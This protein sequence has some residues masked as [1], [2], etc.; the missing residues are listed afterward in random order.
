MRIRTA[1]KMLVLSGF[2]FAGVLTSAGC[3]STSLA[4]GD[5]LSHKE[6]VKSGASSSQEIAWKR[7]PLGPSAA[8]AQ[9]SNSASDPLKTAAFQGQGAAKEQA[10][11]P[12]LMPK[13]TPEPAPQKT[14]QGQPV[15]LLHGLHGKHHGP[16]PPIALP[17][18]VN[19]GTVAA[20][21][22]AVP[23]PEYIIRPPDVLLIESLREKEPL[24]F[25]QPIFGPHAVG[26]D[27]KINLGLY[28]QI[29]VAGLTVDQ[30]RD[31]V[32]E[33]VYRR[34]TPDEKRR[35]QIV[36]NLKLSVT[37][38]NSSV[39]YV[40]TDGAGL[41]EQVYRLPV[42][43]NDTV[44]DAI[45]HVNGLPVFSSKKIWVARRNVGPG[46]DTLLPVDWKGITQTGNMNTNWQL[47]P[48]DRIYVQADSMRRF[49]NNLGKFL[50]P[51]ERVFGATL[52]G[53]QTVNTIKNG[54]TVL[55]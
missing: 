16:P 34:G 55:R 18:A 36:E 49:N 22:S 35:K 46:P 53:A 51:I 47:M 4:K 45:S 19:E 14:V 12:E 27:G 23:I 11:F 30:A 20:M 21:P 38:Y 15:S 52:L 54:T 8:M 25:I 9:E 7:S 13:P 17:H 41:G 2:L 32:A 39:Y 37:A 33:A 1:G 42:T 44:L 5:G 28:G 3:S 40:I 24:L 6:L 26:P 43:G 29:Q 50:E 31:A 48:G 10:A